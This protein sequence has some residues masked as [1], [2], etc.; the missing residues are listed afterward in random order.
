MVD[1]SILPEIAPFLRP[2]C[3][4]RRL[5]MVGPSF[6][7]SCG[8]RSGQVHLGNGHCVERSFCELERHDVT[9]L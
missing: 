5:S 9:V 2:M 8:D 7:E 1:L 4:Q 6:K 3:W